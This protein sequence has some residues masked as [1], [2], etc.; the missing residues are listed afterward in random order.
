MPRGTPTATSA[1]ESQGPH[2][3]AANA[4]LTAVGYNFRLV[5]AWLRPLFHKPAQLLVLLHRQL[6]WAAR[7]FGVDQAVGTVMIEPSASNRCVWS[8]SFTPAAKRRNDG[9]KFSCHHDAHH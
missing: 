6:P 3:D 8:A 4:I 9:L 1:A 7:R 5:L 2:R